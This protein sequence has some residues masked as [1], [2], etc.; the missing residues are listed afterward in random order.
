MAAH[1]HGRTSLVRLAFTQYLSLKPAPLMM[2]PTI[3]PNR[4]RADPKISMTRICGRPGVRSCRT[5]LQRPSTGGQTQS[6][7]S[8][9][10]IHTHP[11]Q[12]TQATPTA[13]R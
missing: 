12:L 11:R 6:N 13:R 8:N 3:T 5:A 4:P 2:I 10:A 7:S 9:A 1:E